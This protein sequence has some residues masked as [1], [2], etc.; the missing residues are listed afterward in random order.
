MGGRSGGRRGWPWRPGGEEEGGKEREL[1]CGAGWCVDSGERRR[2]SGDKVRDV[3]VGVGVFLLRGVA[4][5][6]IRLPTGVWI[7]E[8][9][10]AR[11]ARSPGVARRDRKSVV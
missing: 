2:E 7:G 4:A 3:V 9:A 10:A 11:A 6:W 5:D 8:A 1:A